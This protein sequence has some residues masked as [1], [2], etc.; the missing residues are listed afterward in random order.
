M[1]K[2]EEWARDHDLP[3]FDE[4]VHL[5]DFRIED[6]LHGRGLHEDVEVVTDHCR[7]AHAASVARA[8]F[9]CYGR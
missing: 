4:S 7:R 2:P 1:A 3:F 6:E 9:R 5:P 8:G